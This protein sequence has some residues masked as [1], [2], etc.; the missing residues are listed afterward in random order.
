MIGGPA[1]GPG[2]LCCFG[3]GEGLRE[4]GAKMPRLIGGR[5]AAGLLAVLLVATAVETL[6]Q[7]CA[8]VWL[9]DGWQE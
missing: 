4:K 3:G 1:L 7:Q 9:A 2:S 5:P 8:E 6:G